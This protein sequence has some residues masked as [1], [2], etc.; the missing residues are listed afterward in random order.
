MN[1][2]FNALAARAEQREKEKLEVKEFKIGDTAVKFCKL[3]T[4]KELEYYEKFSEASGANELIDFCTCLIYECCPTLQEPELHK[5]LNVVD[6]LDS[7]RKLLSAHEIDVLGG[8]LM[9]W[10]GL[11]SFEEIKN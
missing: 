8:E 10:I 7:V 11:I 2:L 3:N 9:R 5:I 6:P 4:E 1:E